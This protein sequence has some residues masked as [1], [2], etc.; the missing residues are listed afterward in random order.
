VALAYFIANSLLGS[1]SSNPTSIQTVDKFNTSFGEVD[2][3][4]FNS[5]AI[6]PTVQIVISDTDTQAP[7]E[8]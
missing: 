2:K 7:G 6:N 8:Q 3:T 1:V 4:V 5:D